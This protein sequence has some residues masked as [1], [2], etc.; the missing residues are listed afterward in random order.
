MSTKIIECMTGEEVVNAISEVNEQMKEIEKLYTPFV[1][2]RIAE[3]STEEINAVK[4]LMNLT[5]ELMVA[6]ADLRDTALHK[7]GIFVF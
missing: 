7:F 5:H 4:K 1:G 2:K 6:R 3:L